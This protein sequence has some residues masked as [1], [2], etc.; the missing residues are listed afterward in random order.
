M[1][2]RPAPAPPLAGPEDARKEQMTSHCNDRGVFDTAARG[3]K[4][5]SRCEAQ[6]VG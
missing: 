3:V 5:A 4:T 6:G 2:P 1:I